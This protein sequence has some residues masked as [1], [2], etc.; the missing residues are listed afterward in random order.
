[1]AYKSIYKPINKNKYHGDIESIVCRS[2]WERKMCKYLDL[3]K[4]VLKWSSEE[5]SIPYFSNVDNKW[6]KYYPDFLAEILDS[7]NNIKKYMI[8]VKP[9]KQTKPPKKKNSRTYLNEMKTFSINI[10]KWE[11]AKKVCDENG[12]IFKIIT[13]KEIFK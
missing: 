4:N 10:S 13:E 3:N 11:A 2:S 12:W 9:E 8:E 5:I 7:N 6:H 1:M